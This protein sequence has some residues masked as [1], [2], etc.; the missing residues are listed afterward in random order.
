MHL[1]GY[2][3]ENY[4]DAQSPEHK[5]PLVLF[6]RIANLYVDCVYP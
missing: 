3:Y 1:V 5:V 2:F 6:N 4:H